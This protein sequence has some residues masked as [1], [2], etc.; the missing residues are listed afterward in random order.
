MKK[1]KW[2][3]ML[4]LCLIVSIIC[5]S[6]VSAAEVEKIE[7]NKIAVGP[8]VTLAGEN[9]YNCMVTGD[10][11]YFRSAPYLNSS[12]IIRTL[13][14]GHRLWMYQSGMNVAYNDGYYWS[15]VKDLVNGDWGYIASRYFAINSAPP[16][17]LV[18]P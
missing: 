11:V 8:L 5:A 13:Y 9:G 2:N 15:Y 18:T 16:K 1:N 7:P 3:I 12:N 14:Y 4:C 17:S 6:S 10:G